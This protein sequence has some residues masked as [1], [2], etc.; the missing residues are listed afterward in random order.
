MFTFV[1][2]VFEDILVKFA[3][4]KQQLCINSNCVSTHLGDM[5]D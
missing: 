5:E 3:L 1:G 2:S 4:K